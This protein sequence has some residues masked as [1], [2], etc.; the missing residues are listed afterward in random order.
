[1]FI[2][3]MFS[4]SLEVPIVGAFAKL[5]AGEKVVLKIVQVRVTGPMT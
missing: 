4:E 5:N 1:M 3:P 2:P